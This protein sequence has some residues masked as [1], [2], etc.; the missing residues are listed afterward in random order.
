MYIYLYIDLHLL[1]T[2]ADHPK[3]KIFLSNQKVNLNCINSSYLRELGIKIKEL[4]NKVIETCL[5]DFM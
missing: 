1:C 5:T 2:Y 4:S 3:S